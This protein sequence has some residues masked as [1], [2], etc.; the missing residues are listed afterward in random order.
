MHLVKLSDISLLNHL[1]IRLVQH[2]LNF[3]IQTLML[4]SI[5]FTSLSMIEPRLKALNFTDP[6]A[7]LG[8]VRITVS[9]CGDDPCPDE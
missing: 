4:Q 8:K 6:K 2:P 5:S 9:D 7:A 1:N 3:F